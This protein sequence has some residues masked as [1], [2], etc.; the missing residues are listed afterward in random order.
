MAVKGNQGAVEV[1]R[2]IKLY[3]GV[4]PVKVL[5]VNPTKEQ[6]LQY[7]INVT[8][9]PVYVQEG[10]ATRLDFWLRGTHNDEPVTTKLA[11]FIEDTVRRNTDKTKCEWV[12]SFGQSCWSA[13]GEP[14][15]FV[16]FKKEGMRKSFVGEAQLLDF[17]RTWVNASDGDEVS[18][19]DWDKLLTGNTTELLEVYRL[20]KENVLRVMLYVRENEGKFYQDVY[21]YKFVRWNITKHTTWA[22]AFNDVRNQPKG[23][24]SYEFKEFAGPAEPK[25]DSDA[26]DKPTAAANPAWA[27]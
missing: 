19:E 2:G 17:L 11:I 16:W 4:L 25:P 18:I 10:K 21:G 23:T 26:P 6:L 13:E 1:I 15:A 14:P 22:S 24:W 9:E 3:T 5:C 7:G 27:I 8:K 12:N 20:F